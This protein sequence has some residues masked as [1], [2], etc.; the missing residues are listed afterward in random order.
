[1]DQRRNIS[2]FHEVKDRSTLPE[3]LDSSLSF[4]KEIIP[5]KV[6]QCQVFSNPV[7]SHLATRHKSRHGDSHLL[8]GL[9]CRNL[10]EHREKGFSVHL[11]HLLDHWLDDLSDLLE[12]N[13][14][15]RLGQINVSTRRRH[16]QPFSYRSR[17]DLG[18]S[19]LQPVKS[20]ASIDHV[21]RV[22]EVCLI[23]KSIDLGPSLRKGIPTQLISSFP[24]P[25]RGG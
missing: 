4:L 22:L 1:M 17:R 13:P 20:C 10:I 16:D 9:S 25:G 7:Q 15:L 14:L 6:I 18:F 2:R 23:D 19:V 11:R 21:D 12:E 24:G 8:S 3:K 5:V